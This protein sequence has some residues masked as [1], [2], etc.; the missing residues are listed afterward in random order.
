MLI[1]VTRKRKIDNKSSIMQIDL[2]SASILEELLEYLRHFPVLGR[3]ALVGPIVEEVEED[4]EKLHP[5]HLT[6]PPDPHFRH[7]TP[8]CE[9]FL[10]PPEPNARQVWPR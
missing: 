6:P 1:Y 3:G 9:S 4:P 8:H 2:G 5:R 7:L 10:A